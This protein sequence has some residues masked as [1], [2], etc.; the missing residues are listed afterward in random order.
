MATARNLMHKKHEDEFCRYLLSCGWEPQQPKE[1]EIFRAIKGS[2]LCII[3]YKLAA[4][5]HYTLW[6]N[7]ERLFH[8][9]L[10]AR[11]EQINTTYDPPPAL[12]TGS[13]TRMTGG[14]ND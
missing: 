10:E 2:E 12:S 11:K 13:R 4:K 14:P 3:H 1:Y 9:W 5:E 7:S 8:E 6:G